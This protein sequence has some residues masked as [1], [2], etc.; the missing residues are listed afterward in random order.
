MGTSAFATSLKRAESATSLPEG[1]TT[2]LSF[3][4][5]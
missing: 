3:G 4:T 2:S 5:P 1:D